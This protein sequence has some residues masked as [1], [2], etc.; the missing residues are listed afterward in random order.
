MLTLPFGNITRFARLGTHIS[1]ESNIRFW[2]LPMEL[3]EFEN[4]TTTRA[5]FFLGESSVVFW[6]PCRSL[7]LQ[8]PRDHL[9]H[10]H[11]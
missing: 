7:F 8:G 5:L 9:L 10:Q 1:L 11:K 4:L 3:P 6:W 2:V